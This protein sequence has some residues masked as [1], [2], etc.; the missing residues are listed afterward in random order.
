MDKRYLIKY[1]EN[2]KKY[3]P[4]TEFIQYAQY[5]SKGTI[6]ESDVP[7]L[8][9]SYSQNKYRANLEAKGIK[10]SDSAIPSWFDPAGAI[11]DVAQFQSY[12]KKKKLSL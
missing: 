2:L 1:D 4:N 9:T 6:K 10:L 8:Y 5:N 3:V 7:D 11:D 12:L